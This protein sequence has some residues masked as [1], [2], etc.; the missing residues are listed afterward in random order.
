MGVALFLLLLDA[1]N[2]EMP[3]WVLPALSLVGL[4]GAAGAAGWVWTWN[5]APTVLGGM[6]ATDHFA[7]FFRFVLI[8]IAAVASCSRTC[9]WSGAGS[10]GASTTR[11]C[12]SPPPA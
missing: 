7:V 10:T 5:G 12:C 6:V 9:T 11:C 1:F 2:P 3:H 4:A 8:G